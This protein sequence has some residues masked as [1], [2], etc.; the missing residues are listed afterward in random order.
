MRPGSPYLSTQDRLVRIEACPQLPLLSLGS[1]KADI[2]LAAKSRLSSPFA[3]LDAAPQI[4]RSFI[5]R[6]LVLWFTCLPARR[7]LRDSGEGKSLAPLGHVSGA[8]D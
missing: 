4:G 5:K 8:L 7:K 3:L 6:A 1:R 2:P